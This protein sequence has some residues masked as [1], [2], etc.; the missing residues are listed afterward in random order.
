MLEPLDKS[1][2]FR[3]TIS[4]MLGVR[5][6]WDSIQALGD[7]AIRVLAQRA[8]HATLPTEVLLRDL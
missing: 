4:L 7:A 8:A 1:G 2:D 5:D 3:A 6:P